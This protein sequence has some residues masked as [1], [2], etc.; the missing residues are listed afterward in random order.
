[1]LIEFS[2]PMSSAYTPS[3]LW[4]IYS[5]VNSWMIEK[6]CLISNTS[7]S[8]ER[9]EF[10]TDRW[11]AKK[12]EVFSP[13][14]VHKVIMHFGVSKDPKNCLRTVTILLICYGLLRVDDSLKIEKKYLKLNKEGKYARS[15]FIS[16]QT[17]Q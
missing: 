8:S 14:D 9:L 7:L 4:V 1:M 13:E 3:T 16:E 12:A 10:K 2:N 15:I 5:C 6:K 11:M 17:F